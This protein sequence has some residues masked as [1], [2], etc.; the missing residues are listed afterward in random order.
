MKT[1]SYG[2]ELEVPVIDLSSGRSAPAYDYIDDL[3]ELIGTNADSPFSLKYSNT[4]F[5]YD[6]GYNNIEL[7]VGPV[8]DLTAL[9]TECLNNF[10]KVINVLAA[11][12]LGILNMSE[13]PFQ[14]TNEEAYKKFCL[15]RP[16][17]DYL[18]KHRNWKHIVGIDAK[19]QTSPCTGI[20]PADSIDALNIIMAYSPAFIALYGN[21]PFENG[22]VTGYCANRLSMWDKMFADTKFSGDHKITKFPLKPFESLLDYFRWMLGDGTAMYAIHKQPANYKYNNELFIVKDSPSLFDFIKKDKWQAKELYTGRV[23][24]ICPQAFHF[25]YHQFC[26]LSDARIRFRIKDKCDIKKLNSALS[27]SKDFDH[28][29]YEYAESVYIEGRIPC[30]NLPDSALPEDVNSSVIISSSALQ[31]GLLAN[32]AKAL[33]H[34]SDIDWQNIIKMR[35]SAIISGYCDDT[36][37]FCKEALSIAKEGLNRHE[38][39]MLSYP[40]YTIKTGMNSAQRALKIFAET[41]DINSVVDSRLLSCEVDIPKC[42]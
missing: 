33:K 22:N 38:H 37:E 9:N 31:K 42:L 21:S 13:H 40:E 16:L 35:E 12:G 4:V 36:A 28:F 24:T 19:A 11:K 23:E 14:P 30:T 32:S 25:G 26:Q 20:K 10:N 39:W 18:N 8:S 41:G 5:G 27:N 6:N 2:I 3:S 34:L 1:L 29:F 15:P 17:Y 7:S